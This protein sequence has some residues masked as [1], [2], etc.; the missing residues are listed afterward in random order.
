MSSSPSP[1]YAS[2]PMN[3]FMALLMAYSPLRCSSDV[4]MS[5]WELWGGGG[6][7]LVWVVADGVWC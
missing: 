4:G 7:G 3:I 5:S 6:G 1:V 2:T